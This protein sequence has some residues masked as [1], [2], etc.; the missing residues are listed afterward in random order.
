MSAYGTKKPGSD[1]M[2]QLGFP[3]NFE[4]AY[5]EA[6]IPEQYAPEAPMHVAAFP[7]GHDL[8]DQYHAMKM[9][10]AHRRVMN[11]VADTRRATNRAM[12]SHAGY[13]GMPR[14]VLSQRIYANPSLGSGSADI[15]KP[16]TR[17]TPGLTGGVLRT[18]EGQEYGQRLLQARVAQLNAIDEAA[19]GLQEGEPITDLSISQGVAD[20]TPPE[21][22]VRL[23][24][25]LD[26]LFA[27]VQAGP[28]AYGS[29]TPADLST[30]ITLLISNAPK[31][32]YSELENILEIVEEMAERTRVYQGQVEDTV[33]RMANYMDPLPGV[34][35][36]PTSAERRYL[37]VYA[38]TMSSIILKMREYLARMIENVNKSPNERRA[39]SRS[40]VKNLGLTSV[41]T[42]GARRG[43]RGQLA[44]IQALRDAE[45]QTQER[46]ARRAAM[47]P[48]APPAAAAAA[49]ALQGQ[50][51]GGVLPMSAEF[52]MPAPTREDSEQNA[53]GPRARFMIDERQVF[54]DNSGRYYGQTYQT[55][56]EDG[57]AISHVA[58]AAANGIRNPFRAPAA[59][60]DARG[61]REFETAMNRTPDM[62]KARMAAT[63]A[64]Q[65]AARE[66]AV[67]MMEQARGMGR[68]ER[69]TRKEFSAALARRVMRRG[70]GE[71]RKAAMEKMMAAL[72]TP[73]KAT[74]KADEEVSD[75]MAKPRAARRLKKALEF[76]KEPMRPRSDAIV[77][78]KGKLRL[79]NVNGKPHRGPYHQMPDGA[80]HSGAKHTKRSKP[81]TVAE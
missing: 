77:E 39:A 16:I 22:M 53:R 76:G 58:N 46:A 25:L 3:T 28:A 43:E 52:S 69:P 15:Y 17:E 54:G 32:N 23:I 40:A 60:A 67:A 55:S 71:P 2:I 65:K 5:A 74:K 41:A 37:N 24:T 38:E 6:G 44:Q 30:M 27:V 79:I 45:E 19:A 29:F 12:A 70:A 66:D 81:L 34:R 51:R 9:A 36:V 50:G 13:W 18:K 10:E 56:P 73:E 47:R 14:P 1:L 78:G 33:N 20:I 8:Q 35:G 57:S 80:Y 48:R 62:R 64:A 75:I 63:A 59:A 26:Q 4:D 61:E 7:S 42:I 68:V 72:K 21:S 11:A 31:M 49:A